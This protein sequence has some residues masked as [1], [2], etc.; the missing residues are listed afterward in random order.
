MNRIL[1]I[2]LVL[3]ITT[4]LF[5]AACEAPPPASPRPKLAQDQAFTM[6]IE[7]VQGLAQTYEAKEY[8]ALLFPPLSNASE[9]DEELRA[10][11]ITITGFPLEARNGFKSAVWFD[12]DVD[13]H[14]SSFREPTWVVY[15]YGQIVPMGGAFM[16]EADIE[17]L[18]IAKTLPATRTAPQPAPAPTPAPAPRP[19][20]APPPPIPL[21]PAMGKLAPDFRLPSLDGKDI[22][23]SDFRGKLVVVNF[24]ALSCDPCRADMPY[25]EAVYQEYKNE[26]VEFIGIHITTLEGEDEV[27][28]FVQGGGY[29]WTFVLDTAGEVTTDYYKLLNTRFIPTSFF[30]DKEGVIR[31]VYGAFRSKVVIESYLSYLSKITT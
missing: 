8:V 2:S 24:W 26:D 14:F 6:I 11:V 20:P 3:I 1:T 31:V 17:Q 9:Y 16:I 13:E 23:L 19:A 22:S 25:I 4:G 28:Q 27:R 12:G 18:N 30:L 29:S 15:D 10:W 21:S 7:R 5:M